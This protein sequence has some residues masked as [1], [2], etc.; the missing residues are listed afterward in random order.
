MHTLNISLPKSWQALTDIQLRFAYHLLASNYS[1][2]Q[3]RI[4]CLLKWGDIKVIARQGNIFIVKHK[5]HLFPLSL[6]QITEAS[7]SLNWLGEIPSFPVQL[8]RICFH[9]PVRADFQDV[10]FED[11]LTLDNLYQG[12]L[13]T[14]RSNLLQDMAKILYR[15]RFIFLRREE[16]LS[17]FYWLTAVKQM[18]ARLFPNFLK[19]IPSDNAFSNAP[20]MK[21][22]Q[23]SMNAQIRA[24]TGGDITKE[25]EV[26]KMNCWRALTELDAK[27]KDA[28]S[29]KKI[30]AS[31]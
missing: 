30:H 3:V 24:L 29:I 11:Y 5:G 18:F 14:Q 25:S 13:Q 7:T 15:T 10:S 27:A 23:D 12:F 21:D 17:I 2:P 4:H 6:M 1:L 8:S 26:L 9:H 20:S 19:R 31:K 22:L 16:E 28:E